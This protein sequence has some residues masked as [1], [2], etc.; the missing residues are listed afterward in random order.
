TAFQAP[1]QYRCISASPRRQSHSRGFGK[2]MPIHIVK[3]GEHLARIAA[4]FGFQN[5]RAIWNN[6]NNAALKAKRENPS[7]L[8]PGDEVFIPD[9]DE[10]SVKVPTDKR[11]TF[12]V[13]LEKLFLRLRIRSVDKDLVKKTDYV[14]AVG[15]EIPNNTRETG[16]VDEEIGTEV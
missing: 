7:V 4:K 2:L 5:T 16:I 13:A 3:P 11:H 1:W 8:A 6:P 14:L 10:S 12:Q 9:K 15:K